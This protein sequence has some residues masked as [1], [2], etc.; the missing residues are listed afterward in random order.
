V[1]G[2]GGIFLFAKL[3]YQARSTH[4]MPLPPPI[5]SAADWCNQIQQTFLEH[6]HRE[7]QLQ[8]LTDVDHVITY[9]NGT[10]QLWKKQPNHTLM[11][12]HSA[13]TPALQ[14]E[15]KLCKSFPHISV[16][17]YGVLGSICAS[18]IINEHHRS[19]L[20]RIEVLLSQLNRLEEKCVDDHRAV[21]ELLVSVVNQVKLS[22]GLN[23][24]HHLLDNVIKKTSMINDNYAKKATQLQL[25]GMHDIVF[26]WVKHLDL[27]KTRVLIAVA[28]GPKQNLIEG[29]YFHSLYKKQGIET[30]INRQ[31]IIYVEMLAKQLSTID[32]Q[33]LIGVLKEKM[34]N[35]TIAGNMLGNPEA[36]NQD[37][38]GRFAPRVLE[39]LCPYSKRDTMTDDERKDVD[40]TVT[41]PALV[42]KK[43]CPLKKCWDA[44]FYKPLITSQN[45]II[46]QFKKYFN[47]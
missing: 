25:Q 44:R 42:D 31:H 16:M 21:I 38:L 1:L 22:S 26:P 2:A 46:E 13:D 18:G 9:L 19:D 4:S 45:Q 30:E 34:L 20:L 33:C 28:P 43:T 35:R 10:L 27:D 23:Q 11:I 41:K 40:E 6:H 5:M 7:A 39:G 3:Q 29:Q 24:I 8:P 14:T 37:V 15:Y 17:I 32:S 12:E 36:M 47:I